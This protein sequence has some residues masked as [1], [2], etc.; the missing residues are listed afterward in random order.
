MDTRDLDY[1]L[2]VAEEGALGRAAER[3]GITQPSLTKAIQRVESQL[4]MPVFERTSRGMRPSVAGE[5]F[6]ARARRIQLEYHDAVQEVDAVRTGQAGVLRIGYSP[7][8]ANALLAACR[9]LLQDRPA[10]RVHLRE[11]L[12]GPAVEA[13]QAGEFDV[14]IAAMPDEAL[15]DLTG[16]DLFEDR[17]LLVADERHP[18]HARGRLTLAELV[19]H[20]WMLP[21]P[22]LRVRRHIDQA[23]AAKGLPMP[24]V[25]VESDFAAPSVFQLLRG[26]LLISGAGAD[27]LS[28]LQGVRALPLAPGELDLVRLIGALYRTNAYLSPICER[29]LELLRAGSPG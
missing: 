15:P 5:A 12:A 1:L 9:R 17:I 3:L 13:L 29:L 2:A 19:E 16:I 14:V 22:S 7:S 24:V 10:A 8:A 28:G 20:E 18:L 25:R 27:R 21:A 23:F 11:R 4:G 6:I 26:S